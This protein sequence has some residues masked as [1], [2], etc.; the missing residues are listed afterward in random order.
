MNTYTTKQGDMWDSI[1]KKLYGS[2]IYA[3]NLMQANP[4]HMATLVFTAGVVLTVPDIEVAS[5]SAT[6][7]PWRI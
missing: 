4:T 1:S 3:I 5:S 6:L 2:E 7:P